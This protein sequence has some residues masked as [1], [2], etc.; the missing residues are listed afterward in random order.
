VFILQWRPNRH[1]SFRID[2]GRINRRLLRKAAPL[3]HK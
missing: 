2:N 1:K 3:G